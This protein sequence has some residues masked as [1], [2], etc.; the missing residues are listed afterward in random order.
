MTL[1]RFSGITKEKLESVGTTLEDIQ[2]RLKVILHPKAIL[3]GHS[4]D[5]DLTAMKT[6]HP[7]LIDTSISF[8]HPRG[9][10]LKSSLKYLTQKHLGREIQ[11]DHGAG[12][13]DSVEDARACLDLVKFK[14][15][16]GMAWGTSENPMES[17]FKRLGRTN[18]PAN[19][20]ASPTGNVSRSGAI[21]DWGQP[22][23]AYGAGGKVCIACKTDEEVVQGVSTAANGD[24]EGSIVSGGGVD[25]VWARLREL[26][27]VRGWWNGN[28][29]V[30]D[31]ER[32][33]K[34][35][36]Q[37][38]EQDQKSNGQTNQQSLTSAVADTVSHISQIYSRLPSCTAF[39]VY[40]GSGDPQEMSRLH[41]L[42][43]QFKREYRTKK[44]DELSVQWTDVE[45]QALKAAALAA[46]Q[47]IGL[48]GIK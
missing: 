41:S 29:N 35:A 2:Q 31:G 30:N 42:Q 36:D 14:C 9:P 43:Q 18:R 1:I 40:S 23:K 12:G 13:H 5:S 38:H 34:M 11:K 44:W 3:A 7:F 47:G 25:F 17:I 8:P 19:Q 16:K 48:I 28:R 21:V 26:E 10:P 27:A 33:I 37:I 20:C 6:T 22:E 46:R 45:E 39:I 15:E 24:L 4:L 32:A